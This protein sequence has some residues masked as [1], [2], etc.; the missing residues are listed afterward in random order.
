MSKEDQKIK[1]FT[2]HSGGKVSY[3]WMIE[4]PDDDIDYITTPLASSKSKAKEKALK[5]LRGVIAKIEATEVEV[6]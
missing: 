1:P 6:K 2:Q 3:G 4:E 5:Y